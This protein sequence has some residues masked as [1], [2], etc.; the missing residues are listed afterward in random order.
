MMRV[1]QKICAA[2][3]GWRPVF[4]RLSAQVNAVQI[5][6]LTAM[7][8]VPLPTSVALSILTV[9]AVCAL[10]AARVKQKNVRTYDPRKYRL[11]PIDPHGNVNE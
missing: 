9:L 11:E 1:V 7:Q 5:I 3:S 4:A 8:F 10:G 6:V 2:A